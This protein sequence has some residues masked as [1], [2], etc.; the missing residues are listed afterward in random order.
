[1]KDCGGDYTGKLDSDRALKQ[2]PAV[3]ISQKSIISTIL[4]YTIPIVYY[5]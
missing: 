1:M 5:Q 2:H 4:V 3:Y